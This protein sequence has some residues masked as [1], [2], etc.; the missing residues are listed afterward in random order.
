MDERGG[1]WSYP[2]PLDVGREKGRSGVVGPGNRGRP[3]SILTRQVDCPPR[4]QAP[5]PHSPPDLLLEK[6]MVGLQVVKLRLSQV[7]ATAWGVGEEELVG[8]KA[9]TQTQGFGPAGPRPRG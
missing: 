8:G 3:V 6:W 4:Q 2:A 1:S 7:K 5:C 9:G